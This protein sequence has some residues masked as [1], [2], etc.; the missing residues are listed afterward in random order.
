[1]VTQKILYRGDQLLVRLLMPFL[2]RKPDIVQHLGDFV[3][4]IA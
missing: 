1:M 3:A 2:A 4:P